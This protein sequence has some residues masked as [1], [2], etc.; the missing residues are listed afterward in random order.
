[1]K[2][3]EHLG[4]FARDAKA[5][6]AAKYGSHVRDRLDHAMRRLEEDLQFA[7]L[8]EFCEFFLAI[9]FAGWKKPVK[10]E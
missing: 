7:S 1:M 9:C 3:L 5:A 6:I 2:L 8:V 10:T 4:K